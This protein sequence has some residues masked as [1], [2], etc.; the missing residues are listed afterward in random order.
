MLMMELFTQCNKSKDAKQLFSEC[1]G[2]D[3][4]ELVR[5]EHARQ[6]VSKQI[7]DIYDKKIRELEV[8]LISEVD[9]TLYNEMKLIYTTQI[10]LLK[11][12][13]NDDTD[14]DESD[15]VR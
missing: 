10:T 15:G 1:I 14:E 11:R 4:K 5:A 13:I 12:G 9:K 2:K 3:A 7:H 8:E 6:K